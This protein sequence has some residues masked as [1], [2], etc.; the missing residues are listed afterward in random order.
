MHQLLDF[1]QAV[2]ELLWDQQQGEQSHFCQM[3]H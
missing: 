3:I 1:L 2:A